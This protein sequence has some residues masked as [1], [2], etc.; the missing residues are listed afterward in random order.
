MQAK[1]SML[2]K[3]NTLNKINIKLEIRGNL[4]NQNR[5]NCKCRMITKTI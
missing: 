1:M 2:K 5:A 3:L 4:V